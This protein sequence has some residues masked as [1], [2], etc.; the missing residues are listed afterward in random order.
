MIMAG[1]TEAAKNKIMEDVKV[2][3]ALMSAFLMSEKS[4]TNWAERNDIR[5]TTKTAVDVLKE[6]TGLT[7]DE[8]LQPEPIKA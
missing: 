6:T 1:I 2:R 7:E 5:L 8:I 3:A 4:V